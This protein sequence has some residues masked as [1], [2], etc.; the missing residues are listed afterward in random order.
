MI[1]YELIY[2]EHPYY[3]CKDLDDLKNFS[4]KDITIPPL[5]QK[6]NVSEDC[7]DLMQQMLN[8]DEHKRITLSTLFIHPWIKDTINIDIKTI[9]LKTPILESDLENKNYDSSDDDFKSR[10]RSSSSDESFYGLGELEHS[11][12]YN[13]N[14]PK[15]RI[16]T[17]R[18]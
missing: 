10:S 2:G 17:F 7:I 1:L 8:K 14:K 3:E 13:I 16:A 15:Y 11:D 18:K 6:L 5:N 12:S 4:K 9:A